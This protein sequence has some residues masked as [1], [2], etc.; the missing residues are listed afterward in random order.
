MNLLFVG[1]GFGL[2]EF[3]SYLVHRY[4]FHGPFWFIHRSHHFPRKGLIEANDGFSLF[5]TLLAAG[6]ITVGVRQ[7]LRSPLLGIA[8]G[9]TLY[10]LLYFLFHDMMT[11]RR[12]KAFEPSTRWLSSI[13]QSHRK[14]HQ[15]VSKK[16]QEPF[17][18]LLF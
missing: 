12:F 13:R 16:G 9:V 8:T 7:G 18:F 4:L 6:G 15:S 10:G 17:G 1:I 2:M 5:F 11:H 3:F 14:H